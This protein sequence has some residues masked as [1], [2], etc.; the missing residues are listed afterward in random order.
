MSRTSRSILKQRLAKRDI[1]TCRY[2]TEKMQFFGVQNATVYTLAHCS[3]LKSGSSFL[4]TNFFTLYPTRTVPIK[5]SH[6]F[7]CYHTE[8][9]LFMNK[10]NNKNYQEQKLPIYRSIYE[11]WNSLQTEFLQ[12]LN[13]TQTREDA[14][15]KCQKFGKIMTT[16][17]KSCSVLLSS[18][19]YVGVVT[20]YTK[21]ET[22]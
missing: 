5:I 18:V 10:L 6:I 4:G 19:I 20:N 13:E 3:R 15:V 14:S 16:M 8:F 17:I 7:V 21:A 12:M 2:Q 9:L 22:D 11:I 1:G